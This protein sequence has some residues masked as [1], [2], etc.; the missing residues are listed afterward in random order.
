M[1]NKFYS[2]QVWTQDCR[3]AQTCLLAPGFWTDL[4]TKPSKDK[5]D[6][7]REVVSSLH[8]SDSKRAFLTLNI[9]QLFI[10][11]ASW[12]EPCQQA[13]LCGKQPRKNREKPW[14]T[15]AMRCWQRRYAELTRRREMVAVKSWMV[16]L[17]TSGPIVCMGCHHKHQHWPCQI[18][19]WWVSSCQSH[20][21]CLIRRFDNFSC[22]ATT[23]SQHKDSVDVHFSMKD[24]DAILHVPASKLRKLWS[25]LVECRCLQ[26]HR[27]KWIH[28][29][30]TFVA[31]ADAK[32]SSGWRSAKNYYILFTT[33]VGSDFLPA[34]HQPAQ[35]FIDLSVSPCDGKCLSA[36]CRQLLA[37]TRNACAQRSRL[38]LGYSALCQLFVVNF[39]KFPTSR[40]CEDLRQKSILWRNQL[41]TRALSTGLPRS[42][43]L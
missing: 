37:E 17:G 3:T 22:Y 42:N 16:C 29:P 25:W 19:S 31:S 2:Q 11:S 4:W 6:V 33:I 1:T 20:S 43:K 23:S 21:S 24:W 34:Y 5:H 38:S 41:W 10:E 28:R 14:N 18:T 12:L 7:P 30:A 39:A 8:K 36:L 13:C 32:T 15:K 40:G 35:I 9:K 26:W 27:R